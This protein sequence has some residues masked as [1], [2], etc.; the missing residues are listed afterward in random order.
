MQNTLEQPLP[1]TTPEKSQRIHFD[2]NKLWRLLAPR[3]L[4][5]V[6]VTTL[7]TVA[8]FFVIHSYLASFTTLFT[9]NISVTQYLAAG[10]NLVMAIISYILYMMLPGLGI[11]AIIAIGGAILYSA[12][13]FCMVR[14]KRISDLWNWFRGWWLPVYH[15]LRPLLRLILTLN[16]LFLWTLV[17]LMVIALGLVYGTYYYGQSP[18]MLGGGMP[19]D[20]ILVFQEE[21]PTQ[22]SVWGFPINK[23]NPQQSER[24]QLLIELTDGVIVRDV[25]TNTTTLVKN[26][27]LQGI[28]GA[29]TPTANPTY[30]LVSPTQPSSSVNP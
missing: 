16:K 20:V 21:Q 30:S 28:I 27:V 13:H 11:G 8:G 17:A 24:V 7:L 25:A 5:L 14:S 2:I 18:R 3:L 19:V 26:D 9:F 4:N 29:S 15:R 6:A 12:G 23:S 22:T 1:I 10:I